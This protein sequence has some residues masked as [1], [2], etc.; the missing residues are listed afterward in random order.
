MPRQPRVESNEGLYHVINRGN[1]RSHIFETDGARESFR[2]VIFEACERFS[3][4][5]SAYCLMGNHYHLCIGTPLGNLSAGM[6]W[7]GSTYAARFNRFRKEQGRLFQGRFKSLLVEPGR[8]WLDLVDY[9]HLNPVRAGLIEAAFL[10]KYPWTSLSDFPKIKSRPWFLDCRWMAYGDGLS[11]SAKGWRR[12]VER[13]Q[14]LD[15]SDEKEIDA[16]DRRMCRGWCIGA[17][18]FRKS[19]AKEFMEKEGA[20]RLEKEGLKEANRARWE[21][22]LAM[23]LDALG[24]GS[25]DIST[26]AKSAAWKLAIASKL[27]SETSVTNDWLGASLNMGRG[28]SV[29]AIL[30]RYAKSSKAKCKSYRQLSNLIIEY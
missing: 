2:R 1:Y 12:Y 15:T 29:S 7:L 20:A 21:N 27:K 6:A 3:W 25:A 28:R 8:H 16:L 5:L 17:E 19:V 22:G 30:G 26:D 10:R 14:L 18:E 23:C 9:I 24:K 11:D 13:L 4:E